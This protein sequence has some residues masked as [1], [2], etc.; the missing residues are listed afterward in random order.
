MKYL[1]VLAVIAV[2]IMLWRANRRDKPQSSAP[3]PQPKPSLPLDMVKCAACPVHLPRNEATTGSRGVY[4]CAEH[5][6]LTEG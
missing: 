6:Q 4:C 5:R 3:P 2:A 1:V